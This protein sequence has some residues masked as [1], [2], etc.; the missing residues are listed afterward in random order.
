M[1][2]IANFDTISAAGGF[3]RPEAD[4]YVCIIKHVEDQP[5]RERLALEFDIVEGEFK[6]YAFDTAERAGFWPLRCNKSYSSKALRFFKSFIEAVEQTNKNY[7]WNWDESTLIG[8]GVGIVF[9]EEEYLKR[10]GSIGKALAPF[11]FTT[12]AK[13]RNGEFKVPEPKRINQVSVPVQ[14]E[15][16]DDDSDLPF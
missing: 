9:R 3:S 13:I 4:G 8:K 11:E 7:V 16:P 1:K 5:D 12:A 2:K 14:A 10:D 15:E 6:N